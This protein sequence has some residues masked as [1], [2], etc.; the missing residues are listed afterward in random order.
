MTM[1]NICADQMAEYRK[2][3]VFV[4]LFMT[5]LDNLML[6]SGE[7]EAVTS[8]HNQVQLMTVHKAK[9][10]E[11]KI[12]MLFT[13]CEGVFPAGFKDTDLNEEARL[14]YVAITRAQHNVYLS[15]PA[16]VAK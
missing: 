4:D 6:E 5:L 8:D 10:T 15:Y 16:K 3:G 14:F 12:I 13:L 7:H 11:N 9:G 1:Q 2:E